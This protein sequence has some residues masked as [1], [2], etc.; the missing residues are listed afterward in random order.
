PTGEPAASTSAEATLGQRGRQRAILRE[1]VYAIN[2]A[3]FVVITAD[4]VYRMPLQGRDELQSLMNWQ[5]ELLEI[6]GFSPVVIGEQVEVVDP[7]HPESTVTVDSIGIVTAHDGPSLPPGEIIAPAVGTDRADPN[8]H[9]NYQDPEGFL[10]AG[11]R[12]GRQYVPLTDGTYF[13]NR[14]FATVECKPKTLVPIGYVGVVVSYYG[15]Q[16][17][18]LSGDAFRHGE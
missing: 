17:R 3:L 6:D 14:W 5:K 15:R 16:G 10:R 18:D 8:F 7:L 11:G 2:Q 13:I 1:G 4:S 9:N 12:R